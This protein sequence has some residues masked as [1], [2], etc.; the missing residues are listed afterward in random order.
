MEQAVY[1]NH[2]KNY[3]D[4]LLPETAKGFKQQIEKILCI[5]QS[6]FYRKIKEPD[7]YLT[8]AEKQAIARVYQLQ[9]TYLFPELGETQQHIFAK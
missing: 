3:H 8:I 1:T 2:W 7:R 4:N 5:S 6:A 9:E